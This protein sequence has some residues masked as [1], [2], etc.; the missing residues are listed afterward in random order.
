MP[1]NLVPEDEKA[2]EASKQL[3]QQLH[4][5]YKHE[6]Y[7]TKKKECELWYMSGGQP[8]FVWP[9]PQTGVLIKWEH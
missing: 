4:D 6:C 7:G 9:K 8:V 5:L 2:A 1:F 3:A